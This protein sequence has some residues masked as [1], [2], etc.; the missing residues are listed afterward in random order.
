MHLRD[1]LRYKGDSLG[2]RIR[3]SLTKSITVDMHNLLCQIP[4][5]LQ[6]YKQVICSPQLPGQIEL[7]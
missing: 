1:G 2:A 6:L 5:E 3:D 4:R 7:V